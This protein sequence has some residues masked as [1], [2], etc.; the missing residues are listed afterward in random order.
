VAIRPGPSELCLWC[1]WEIGL[2]SRREVGS[3]PTAIYAMPRCSD[4]KSNRGSGRNFSALATVWSVARPFA[5]GAVHKLA[6]LSHSREP[7]WR[8]W[9]KAGAGTTCGGK[10]VAVKSAPRKTTPKQFSRTATSK[11][12]AMG[13]LQCSLCNEASLHR[14]HHAHTAAYNNCGYGSSLNRTASTPA[15]QC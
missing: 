8:Y 7:V 9:R 6:P 13:P 3:T 12:S 1:W 2:V 11:T 15:S 4:Q 10:V 5:M 14:I